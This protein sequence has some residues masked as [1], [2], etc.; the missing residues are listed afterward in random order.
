MKFKKLEKFTVQ[1][2]PWSSK[3]AKEPKRKKPI[4]YPLPL[5]GGD[6]FLCMNALARRES[7]KSTIFANLIRVYY[8]YMSRIIILSPTIFNDVTYE[9]ILKWDKVVASDVVTNEQIE[10]IFQSQEGYERKDP[11][12]EEIL[13][14]IDDSSDDF[15]RRSLRQQLTLLYTRGRHHGI[16]FCVACHGITFFEGPMITNSSQWLIWDLNKSA[17]KQLSAK[18]ATRQMNEQNMEEFLSATTEKPYSF[19]FINNK[20]PYNNKYYIGF[21][22]PYE[23]PEIP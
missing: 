22:K 19:A 3:D 15:K 9:Q 13:L 23:I 8:P 17:L 2:L 6:S 18:I 20:D 7:G 10:A 11:D 14:I 4:P 5:I 12:R 1:P 16:H 21:D